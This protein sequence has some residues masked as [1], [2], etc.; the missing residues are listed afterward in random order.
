MKSKFFTLVVIGGFIFWCLIFQFVILK[1]KGSSTFF[2]DYT[3]VFFEIKRFIKQAPV[4]QERLFL[5]DRKI[6]KEYDGST[7]QLGDKSC[8]FC[9]IRRGQP[10]TFALLCPTNT[11]LEVTY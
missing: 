7:Y 3:D 11:S 5:I 4:L 2:N 9:S 1:N 8:V 6:L 10:I